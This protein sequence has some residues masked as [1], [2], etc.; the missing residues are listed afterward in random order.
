M[1]GA[2]SPPTSPPG[3]APLLPSPPTSSAQSV[4]PSAKEQPLGEARIAYAKYLNAIH[5][6]LHPVFADQYLASFDALPASDPRNISTLSTEVAF[7]VDG[8]TGRLDSAKV[9]RTSGVREF[10]AA[11][12]ESVKRAFPAAPPDPSTWS[13]DGKVY[14]L[15]EFHRGPEACG[16]WNARPF[17]LAF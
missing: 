7:V 3:A 14:A 8:K 10:D 9:T 5:A 16:T 13:S 2:A 15:W 1:P 6:L 17:R 12:I 4:W 11:A